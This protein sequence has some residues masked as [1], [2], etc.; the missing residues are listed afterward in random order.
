[1]LVLWP[2]PLII[3]A[4]CA[5]G[6]EVDVIRDDLR[7]AGADTY[8]AIFLSVP[9]DPDAL[10]LGLAAKA[11]GGLHDPV[12]CVACVLGCAV[13]VLLHGMS[14]LLL[15]TSHLA[16]AR[17]KAGQPGPCMRHTVRANSEEWCGQ[18]IAETGIICFP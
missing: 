5:G 10:Q 16:D 14:F 4:C 2:D 1:M 11:F 15:S 13:C 9:G 8:A 17:G 7:A 3:S 6:E 12:W 18:R